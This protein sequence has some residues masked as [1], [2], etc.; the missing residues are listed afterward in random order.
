MVQYPGILV[1]LTAESLILYPIEQIADQG[2]ARRTKSIRFKRE[3]HWIKTLGTRS[4]RG[5][6]HEITISIQ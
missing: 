3:L 4:S 1:M 2:N 6:N 5:M